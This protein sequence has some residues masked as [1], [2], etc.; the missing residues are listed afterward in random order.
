MHHFPPRLYTSLAKDYTDTTT[1]HINGD[2]SNALPQLLLLYTWG[3]QH[4]AGASQ[5]WALRPGL[6]HTQCTAQHHL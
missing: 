1:Q 3:K 2:T 4:L 5:S 6:L